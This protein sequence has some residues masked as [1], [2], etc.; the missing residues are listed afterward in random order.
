MGTEN[1]NG[2]ELEDA[3]SMCM[4]TCVSSTSKSEPVFQS[5]SLENMHSRHFRS[6]GPLH[7]FVY[8]QLTFMS[9]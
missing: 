5:F 6:L 1:I 2:T 9:K 7:P 3:V 8:F 4:Y